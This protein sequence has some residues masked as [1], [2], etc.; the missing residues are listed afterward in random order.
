MNDLVRRLAIGTCLAIAANAACAGE[1]LIGPVYIK[2]V[3]YIAQNDL[4]HKAGNFELT[5]A[6]PFTLPSG[7]NCDTVYI[8]TMAVNDPDKK[9]FALTTTAQLTRSPVMLQIS[10]AASLNAFPGRCSL[11]DVTITQ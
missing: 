1:G 3:G 7:V 8:T 11:I 9:M 5:M 10:D 4:G 6:A 2:A